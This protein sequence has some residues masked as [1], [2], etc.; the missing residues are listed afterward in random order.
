MILVIA[1]GSARAPSADYADARRAFRT[2]LLRRGPSP[3]VAAPLVLAPDADEITFRSGDLTLRA[4]ISKA[5]PGPPRPAIVFVHGA[6]A[7]RADHWA[8]TQALRDAGYVVMMPILRGENG[9]PGAFSLF[10]DE[11]DDVVAAATALTSRSDVDPTRIFVAGHSNGGTL[12]I[13]AA[14][15]SSRFRAAAALSGIVDAS[16][17]RGAPSDVPFDQQAGAPSSAPS[18]HTSRPMRRARGRTSSSCAWPIAIVCRAPRSCT[19][20]SN[21]SR[22]SNCQTASERRVDFRR[23]FRARGGERAAS[24]PRARRDKQPHRSATAPSSAS[25]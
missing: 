22:G 3:Q 9:S 15:T 4:W 12:A 18:R 10:Y 7:F 24:D 8:G 5:G 2:K 17:I 21:A 23:W 25:T 13:L 1:C 19:S 14:M 11:V 6:S 16:G 20:S